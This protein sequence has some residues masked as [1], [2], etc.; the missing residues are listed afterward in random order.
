MEKYEIF[1]Q[2]HGHLRH[3]LKLLAIILLQDNVGI[4]GP[5]KSFFRTLVIIFKFVTNQ[6]KH[7]GIDGNFWDNYL[8]NLYNIDLDKHREDKLVNK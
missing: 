8:R 6:T 7:C 1:L 4:E 2:F 5:V 3:C